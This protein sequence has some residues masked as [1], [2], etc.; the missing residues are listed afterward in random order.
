MR[1]QF[2]N[3]ALVITVCTLAVVLAAIFYFQ[4]SG[5]DICKA[6]QQQPQRIE[7]IGGALLWES[8][9]SQFTSAVH[10]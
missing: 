7:N 2:I 4:K 9:S 3:H 6:A 1:S 5:N 8:L 10:N